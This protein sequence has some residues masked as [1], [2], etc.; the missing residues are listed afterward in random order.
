MLKENE[1]QVLDLYSQGYGT[2]Y[3]GKSMGVNRSSINKFLKIRGVLIRG[4][5]EASLASC[6]LRKKYVFDHNF[7]LQDS[8]QLA[9]FCG[10]CLADG[11]LETRS[12][13]GSA[14]ITISI[15]KQDRELLEKFCEWSSYPPSCIKKE[16]DN[17]L[18]LRFSDPIL[19]H[20]LEKYGIV[21][22]KTYNPKNFLN[23]PKEFIQP[24]LIGFID[25]DGTLRF[26]NR[27]GYRFGIVGNKLTIDIIIEMIKSIGVD[28]EFKFE[29]PQDKVWKRACFYRKN[30]ICKLVK[31]LNPEIYFYLDRKW[32]PFLD[33][34]S[35]AS[36]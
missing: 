7:F 15:N 8:W 30:D 23:I 33:F 9:Y 1:Q 11:S 20:C 31:A 14:R 10:F 13:G 17:K 2:S 25:G 36:I 28:G 4:K 34:L 21:K 16:K 22:N 29:D 26:D 35:A 32:R 24:F 27:R 6:P 5:L 18:S 19:A 12:G 3:I